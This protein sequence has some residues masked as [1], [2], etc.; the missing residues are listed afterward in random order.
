[1]GAMIRRRVIV[2]GQVQGVFFRDTC[3]TE[4]G[5]AGVSGWVRNAADGTVEAIFEG[6]RAAVEAMCEW[7][8][9]GSEGAEVR[10][11]EVFDEEPQ[12]D[13]SFQVR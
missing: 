2:Q 9:T 7:C 6:N 8:R 13:T 12:G 10:S 11:V 3:H 4:A 5:K 1:M